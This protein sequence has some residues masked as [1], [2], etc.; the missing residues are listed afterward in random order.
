[1]KMGVKTPKDDWKLW[2]DKYVAEGA[3]NFD[4]QKQNE[5]LQAENEKLRET[6]KAG[7]ECCEQLQNRI[8]RLEQA[9]KGR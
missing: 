6:I 7:G 3:K 8:D 5:Q 2:Y 4:L 1:M 9:L